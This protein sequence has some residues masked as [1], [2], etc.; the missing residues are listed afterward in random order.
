VLFSII[1]CN[2]ISPIKLNINPEMVPAASANQNL[3][4]LPVRR[5]GIRP[6]IVA[7]F[8]RIMGIIFP[9]NAFS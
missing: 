8:V 5:K 2:T 3:S 7:S 1:G 6:T 4:S 9:L